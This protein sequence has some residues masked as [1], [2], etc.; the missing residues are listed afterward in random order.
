MQTNSQCVRMIAAYWNSAMWCQTSCGFFSYLFN[1]QLDLVFIST[2]IGWHVHRNRVIRHSPN[3]PIDQ[4]GCQLGPC[5][6]GSVNDHCSAAFSSNHLLTS[7]FPIIPT[8]LILSSTPRSRYRR[9]IY[10]HTHQTSSQL[11]SNRSHQQ[12]GDVDGRD[13]CRCRVVRRIAA[14]TIVGIAYSAYTGV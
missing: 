13:M 5:D 9:I 10:P 8:T 2:C 3:A 12:F 1:L 7:F 11:A 4:T 6:E 14:L